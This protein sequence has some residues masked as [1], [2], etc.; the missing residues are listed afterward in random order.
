M[1]D[2]QTLIKNYVTNNSSVVSIKP[3]TNYH[4]MYVLKYKKSVFFKNL[5]NEYLENCRGSVVDANFNLINYPFTKI[6]N[7]GI[8]PN[9]PVLESNTQVT[10]FRKVN[11]FMMACS[12]NKGQL[13]V[14]TTGS[15]DSKFVS[16]AKEMMCTHMVWADWEIAFSDVELENT[17]V[18]FEV[19]H[20]DDPHIIP[21]NPGVY[22]LGYRKNKWN[23][24]VEH[25]P[26]VLLKLSFK[27][28]CY[29]PAAYKNITISTL[30]EMVKG[31]RHE[32]YVAYTEAGCHAFKIKSPYYL[33]NKWMARNPKI[34]K[35]LNLK[36]DIKLKIDEE[37]HSVVD[38]IRNN[39]DSYSAMNEQERLEWIRKLF[40]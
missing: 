32:G 28:K 19:V 8:E 30:Q 17:T 12:Y 39:A 21:E 7:F 18:M 23:S 37:F 4:D 3:S 25:H 22:V 33:M 16:M 15:L 5:W 11:G 36:N 38:S 29:T 40:N 14:S 1:S 9:A 31:C 27:F 6:Y 35:I 10:A 34:D 26:D 2:Y 13:I 24:P 20:P